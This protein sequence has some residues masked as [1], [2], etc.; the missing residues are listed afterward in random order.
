MS[1]GIDC[2][3]KGEK[4]QMQISPVR[5]T[6]PEHWLPKVITFVDTNRERWYL[7][8]TTATWADL[9]LACETCRA[10]LAR[11][12][13]RGWQRAHTQHA[14]TLALL[15]ATMETFA[16]LMQVNPTLPF[17]QACTQMTPQSLKVVKEL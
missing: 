14:A 4:M 15:D 1:T 10:D 8:S 3:L 11:A 7:L 17:G 5:T 9:V 2:D 6:A 12:R 13:Q 16:P